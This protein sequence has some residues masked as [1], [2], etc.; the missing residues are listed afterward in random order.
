MT[1]KGLRGASVA[2]RGAWRGHQELHLHL[3]GLNGC[4]VSGFTSVEPFHVAVQCPGHETLEVKSC[5]H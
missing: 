4:G 3:L 2:V 5:P 1:F